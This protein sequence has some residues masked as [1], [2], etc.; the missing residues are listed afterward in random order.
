M[1][2]ILPDTDSL[3]G[4]DQQRVVTVKLGG[5]TT[6]ERSVIEQLSQDVA[7]LKQSGYS[8]IIV[9]GGGKEISREMDARG[10]R[11][12]KVA[13]LRITDDA[14]MEAV[15]IVMNRMNDEICGIMRSLGLSAVKVI[16]ADGL[17]ICDRK[18]LAPS[19]E[20]GKEV[21]VDL[22]RV[23][24]VR[25]VRSE[26]LSEILRQGKVPV[27]APYGQ[28]DNGL[29]LNVNADTA[30][31][32]IAGATSKELI[33]LTDVEG[34]ALSDAEGRLADA[35]TVAETRDLIDRGIIHGGMIPKIEACIHAIQCGVSTARIVNGFTD[36]PL[37]KVFS[38]NSIGTKILP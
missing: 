12:K 23:G 14:T 18:E 26:I 28:G 11:P 19:E 20:D 30:A 1:Q 13:G 16:G 25:Q 7:H 15:E 6:D 33:L 34:V 21:L 9:H 4:G 10:I 2:N 3:T 8:F 35:L 31:G 38:D 37:R 17:L 29:S 27:V 24:A 32:S 22:K 36:H 5:S